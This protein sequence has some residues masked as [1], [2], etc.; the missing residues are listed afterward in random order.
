MM[1]GRSHLIGTDAPEPGLLDETELGE[2]IESHIDELEE[3]ISRYENGMIGMNERRIS[4]ILIEAFA[5]GATALKENLISEASKVIGEGDIHVLRDFCLLLS[6]DHIV[7]IS[8]LL[9]DSR[10]LSRYVEIE[11][12]LYWTLA[13]K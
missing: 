8:P 11:R 2:R 3:V 1:N 13:I 6:M 7:T 12:R 9:A 5:N 10:F 4:L